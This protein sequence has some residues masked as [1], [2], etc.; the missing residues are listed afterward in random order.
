M[1]LAVAQFEPVAGDI[2]KNLQKH[3]VLVELAAGEGADLVAF[4]ELSLT[5]YE[6]K[7]AGELATSADDRRLDELQQLADSRGVC[8]AAGLP[9]SCDVGTRISLVLF[10]PLSPRATYSKQLLHEDELPYFVCGQQQAVWEVGQRR[11]VPAICYESLQ[12]GHAEQAAQLG[13]EV[14]LASVAKSA[15]GVGRASSHYPRIAQRFGMTVAMA[16]CVGACDDFQA[17]GQSA[18]WNRQG[19]LVIR[20]NACDEGI[21]LMDTSRNEVSMRYL[22]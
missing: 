7:L 15:V 4:P 13:G 1:R 17:V 9:T 5:G 8:I 19:E 6:P 14:Y 10:R 20:L 11:L 18:I 2:H 16:N 12:D 22:R 21:A 3:R